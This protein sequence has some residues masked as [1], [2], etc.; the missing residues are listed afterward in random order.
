MCLLWRYFI[1]IKLDIE[2]LKASRII[3]QG[4][5]VSYYGIY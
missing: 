2:Q 3:N 4:I 1:V 5:S